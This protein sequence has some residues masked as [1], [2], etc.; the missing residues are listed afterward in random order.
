MAVLARFMSQVTTRLYGPC[1]KN[2]TTLL[3]INQIRE[4]VG[5]W[6]PSGQTPETT[7]GKNKSDLF[8][9]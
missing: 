6:S 9:V 4:K 5:S 8:Y 3:F 1:Y 7:P 2:G